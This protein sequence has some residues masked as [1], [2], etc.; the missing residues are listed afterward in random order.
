MHGKQ[1]A[2]AKFG[3][4]EREKAHLGDTDVDGSIKKM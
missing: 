4:T 2:H 1:D 3:I